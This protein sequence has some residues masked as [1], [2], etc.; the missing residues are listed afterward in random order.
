M[1]WWMKSG[2]SER[3][4]QRA[5]L[6]AKRET[7]NLQKMT[8]KESV[9][10]GN[11]Q[12]WRTEWPDLCSQRKSVRGV[13]TRIAEAQGRWQSFFGAFG[14]EMNTLSCDFPRSSSQTLTRSRKRS[15]RQEK[16]DEEEDVGRHT[17]GLGP[18]SRNKKDWPW[19]NV[20]LAMHSY[21]FTLE[22]AQLKCWDNWFKKI[23]KYALALM[24]MRENFGENEQRLD[25]GGHCN[26][27]RNFT[28][29][30]PHL[31]TIIYFENFERKENFAKQ[32]RSLENCKI[33]N[34]K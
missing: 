24:M 7:K 3:E 10:P 15:E 32:Q 9:P 17:H 11:G 26:S 22:S 1:L 16:E 14:W 31:T 27:W 19:T 34:Q 5:W 23:E 21:V 12:K 13:S 25:Y 4:R 20:K 33:G 30:A 2:G 28:D 8:D 29:S 18:I 6:Q